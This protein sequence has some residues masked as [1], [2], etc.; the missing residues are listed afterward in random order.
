MTNKQTISYKKNDKTTVHIDNH[1]SNLIKRQSANS[2]A[3]KKED[4]I[5]GDLIIKYVNG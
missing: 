2:L 1:D 5:I 4:F 3:V